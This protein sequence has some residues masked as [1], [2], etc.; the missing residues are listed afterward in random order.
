MNDDRL[1]PALLERLRC[2][3]CGDVRL[4]RSAEEVERRGIPTTY[5][6]LFIV[7]ARCPTCDGPPSLHEETPCPS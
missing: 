1:D 2:S 3:T 4:V 7:P 6:A 5:D